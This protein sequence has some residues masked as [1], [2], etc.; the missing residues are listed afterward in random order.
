ML[1]DLMVQLDGTKEDE[2]RLAH[3]EAMAA[4]FGAHLTGL[5]GTPIPE[6]AFAFAGE[7][8][9]TALN[10]ISDLEERMRKEGTILLSRLNER[11]RRINV[12][13]EIRNIV[14]SAID[15]PSLFV[16][17]ARWSDLYI[18]SAPYRNSNSQIGDR[19]FEAVLFDAGHS[20][21]VVPPGN[22]V[23]RDLFNVVVA[24]KDTR[25]SA[26][27]VAEAMPFLRAASQARVVTIDASHQ[28]ATEIARHLDRHGVKVEI[29]AA[30][31][32]GRT[33]AVWLMEE[34][35]KM[36]ADLIVM[37]A[38]GHSRVR[39]WLL[40]GATREML[41]ISDLPILIAH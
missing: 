35:H 29:V 39:E 2:I 21:Y 34:A 10:G 24:W 27:G 3:A 20:I 26:R 38:Y 1:K 4:R 17:E 36:S 8:G 9:I 14:E 37:G 11:F 18:A 15:L 19:I 32:E 12:P 23:R 13:N 40:G 25:E 28:S 22:K 33:V 41:E 6:Y 30:Q 7:A 31:S 5:C 16:T